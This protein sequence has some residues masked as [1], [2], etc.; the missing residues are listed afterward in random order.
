[1]FSWLCPTRYIEAIP[2]AVGS[3]N[4]PS[5]WNVYYLQDEIINDKLG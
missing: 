4:E 2:A 5:D 1:M 3:A